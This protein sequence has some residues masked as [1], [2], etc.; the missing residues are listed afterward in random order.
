MMEDESLNSPEIHSEEPKE[1]SDV[2]K[3]DEIRS[4]EVEEHG[5]EQI[6]ISDYLTSDDTA[7]AHGL[8]PPFTNLQSRFDSLYV[9]VCRSL[10]NF[11]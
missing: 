11:V 8:P 1:Q 5:T 10:L 3:S 2:V 6:L 7:D 9:R 4:D